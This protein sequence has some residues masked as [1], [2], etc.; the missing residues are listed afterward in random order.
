[1]NL[2][3][4]QYVTARLAADYCT[5]LLQFFRVRLIRCLISCHVKVLLFSVCILALFMVADLLAKEQSHT[6]R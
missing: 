4:S 1:M 6:G 3:R 5:F 2:E